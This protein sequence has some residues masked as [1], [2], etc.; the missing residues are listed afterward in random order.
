MFKKKGGNAHGAAQSAE[1]VAAAADVKIRKDRIGR[2]LRK[3]LK[4][5]V[6]DEFSESYMQKAGI[7][8]IMKGVPIPLMKGDVEKFM[9]GG[10]LNAL[11]LAENMTYVMGADP[12]FEYTRNYVAFLNK[13]FNYKIY[14]GMLKKG[15]NAAEK[16][17]LEK[18]C[19]YFRATLCMNPVYLHG[20]YSYA[21]VCRAMYLEGGN[22]EYIGRFKAEAMDYFELT[23]EAHPQFAQ[24]YYYLGY[25]Y[26][27]IG[28]YL[29]AE[30][31]WKDFLKK[32]RTPKDSKEIRGRLMQIAEP[33][34]I[35]Q[36]YN[37]VL[38]EHFGQ[39]LKVLEPFM[40]TRFKTWWPLSYYLGVCYIRL[41]MRDEAVASFKNVLTMNAA[42]LETM[43]E[44]AAIYATENDSENEAKYR[45]KIELLKAQA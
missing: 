31:A 45:K 3:H 28:L 44:L 43:E 39:G 36:G 32:S 27:N 11:H 42:H 1:Q 20:M 24:A 41:G 12:H 14:E 7:A 34:Q 13:L 4:E 40:E 37:L 9:G 25:A 18:A 30:L 15:R 2:Y 17:E 22:E 16:G 5:F 19:I 8:D 35:E 29:K 23:T 26:L 6:F 38:S 33:V 10:G 21:R